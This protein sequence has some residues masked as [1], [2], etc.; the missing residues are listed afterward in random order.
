MMPTAKGSKA[1]GETRRGVHPVVLD[2]VVPD[3]VRHQAQ[4]EAVDDLL[5]HFATLI[6]TSGKTS[7]SLAAK[8]APL[9]STLPRSR[10]LFHAR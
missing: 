9:F 7:C 1:G 8:A 10:Y 2:E 6:S 4:H 5:N 3:H